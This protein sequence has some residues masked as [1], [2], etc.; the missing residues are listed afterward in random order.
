MHLDLWTLALQTINVLVLVWLLAHFLFRPVAGIIAARRA[1]ADAMLSD[2][3]AAKAAAAA[4]TAALAEQ[5]QGLNGDGERIVGAARVAAETERATMLRQTEEA[6]AK[7]HAESR[8]TI[9]HDRDS[10]REA[11]EREAADLAVTIATRLLERL[12]VRVMNQVF[13]EGV[14]E[15]LATRSIDAS[16]IGAPLEVRSAVPLD[17]V[18]QTD[19]RSMLTRILGAAPEITFRTDP[20]L[21][22]GIDLATPHLVVRNSWR[23]D[24]DRIA[25]ALHEDAA[26][27]VA[28]QHVA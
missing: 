23:A 15:L 8:Q 24:L 1:A 3:A 25:G 11:L 7:L 22:A 17:A 5:R 18:S 12:P 19:C 2:A 28:S 9:D 14:A 26:H 21:I 16:L 4:E 6:V 13:M 27:D 20:T 10:M